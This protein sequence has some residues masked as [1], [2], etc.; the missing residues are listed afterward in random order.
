MENRFEN[1][2]E[3][4]QEWG[5]YATPPPTFR[6]DLE[7]LEVQ[8]QP[9]ATLCARVQEMLPSLVENDGTVRPEMAAALFSHLT[10]CPSCAK[11]FD[12]MQRMVAVLNTVPLHPLPMDFT[13]V[14]MQRIEAEMAG[15][16][17]K[18]DTAPQFGA[19]FE[20][21]QNSSFQRIEFSVNTQKSQTTTATLQTQTQ[22]TLFQ[23][24]IAMGA[25]FAALL[26]FLSSAWGRA[27][28]G[29]NIQM[30]REWV[31]QIAQATEDVPLLGWVTSEALGVLSQSFHIL[32][33][34]Y[35]TLGV[36]A[37]KGVFVDM[38]VVTALYFMFQGR[39]QNSHKVNRGG[40]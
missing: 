1:N 34:T 40:H 30:A 32:E 26:L 22:S 21:T 18:Q 25:F 2:K 12:E 37:V 16:Y 38:V 27:T 20:T 36:T 7:R 11:E 33:E 24:V 31:R 6:P 19:T 13:G 10:I 8:Q 17:A 39:K 29:A 15:L 14:I 9:P 5:A 28:L 35:R 3:E 4:R 23:R